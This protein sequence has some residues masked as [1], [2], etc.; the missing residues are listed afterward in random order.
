MGKKNKRKQRIIGGA[1]GSGGAGIMKFTAPMSRLEYVYFTWVTAKDAIKFE[2]AVSK[3][4]RHVGTSLWPRSSAVSKAMSTL[5]TPEFEEPAVPTRAYWANMT[6]TVKIN[7]R[8]RPGADG[9]VEEIHQYWRIGS[10]TS[11][12]RSTRRSARSTTNKC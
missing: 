2:D 5:K 10:T 7:D 11:R 9:A 4:A 6:R 12:S 3:L 8:T 1:G